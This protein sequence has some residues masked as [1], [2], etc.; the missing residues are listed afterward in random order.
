[1]GQSNSCLEWDDPTISSQAHTVTKQ[2]SSPP[3]QS[4]VSV[5]SIHHPSSTD[6]RHKEHTK[7]SY[8]PNS[9][10]RFSLSR[11]HIYTHRTNQQYPNNTTP[12]EPPSPFSLSAPSPHSPSHSHS[13]SRSLSPSL[14]V[15]PELDSRDPPIQRDHRQEWLNMTP[16][17]QS[18]SGRFPYY[19]PICMRYFSNIYVTSCCNNTICLDCTERY[20]ASKV[21]AYL[22]LSFIPVIPLQLAC[23]HCGQ[24]KDGVAFKHLKQ[25]DSESKKLRQYVESPRTKLAMARTEE[26]RKRDISEIN[27]N[28]DRKDS[29]FLELFSLPARSSSSSTASAAGIDGLHLNETSQIRVVA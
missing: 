22:P 8:S 25:N 17:S 20:I 24:T 11:F 28:Q 27:E 5:T 3:L 26:S 13:H 7:H 12:A 23:P 29:L 9:N 18:L 10:S 6:K 21:P 15:D 19:D 16:T 2:P 4:M 1:M 14:R